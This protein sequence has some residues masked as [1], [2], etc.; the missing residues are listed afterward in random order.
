MTTNR[1]YAP[2]MPAFA[3]LIAAFQAQGLAF[4]ARYTGC[5]KFIID[6]TGY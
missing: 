6:I 1:V 5:G 3:A 2:D 4:E